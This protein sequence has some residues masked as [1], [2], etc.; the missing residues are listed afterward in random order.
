MSVLIKAAA[1]ALIL[2]LSALAQDGTMRLV[3]NSE[4]SEEQRQITITATEVIFELDDGVTIFK[5]GV[6]VAQEDIVIRADE[7]RVYSVP[8]DFSEVEHLLALGGVEFETEGGNAT[9]DRGRYEVADRLII[10]EGSVVFTAEETTL[11]GQRLTYDVD[12]GQSRLVGGATAL[13]ET[14]DE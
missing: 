7:V 8:D 9:A 4:K 12:T 1:L 6:N 13:I 5:G 10:L 14:G 3:F 2:T 11:T